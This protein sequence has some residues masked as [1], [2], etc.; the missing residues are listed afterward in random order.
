M[1]F[2]HIAD[3]HLGMQPDRG[4]AWS[5]ERGKDIWRSFEGVIDF[6]KKEKIDLLLIAGDLFHHQPLVRELKELNYLFTTIPQCK[7]VIMAGNHDYLRKD[8]NYLSFKFSKN[9]NMFMSRTMSSFYF[10]DIG[11]EVFGLSYDSREI[12]YPLY[13]NI[14]PSH[15]DRF[16][17]LLAHGGDDKHIPM[18]KEEMSKSGFHY[19]ALGHIHKPEILIPDT[20]AYAG[21][22]EPTDCNDMGS[23][24]FILGE[25]RG[26]KVRIQQVFCNLR[27]YVELQ[28]QVNGDTTN[29]ELRELVSNLI[30]EDGGNN[31]YKVQIIGY[32]DPEVE[33][34]LDSIYPLGDII[35]VEDQSEPDYDF[36]RLSKLH[37]DNLIGRYIHHFTQQGL[38]ESKKNALY[39]GVQALLD[40]KR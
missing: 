23:R 2:V 37:G 33:F 21:S 12:S 39:Y 35:S 20:M 18:K 24:G 16:N 30:E 36:Q 32:K 31:I 29:M 25:C 22:L 8:S 26:S 28:I 34:D 19:I 40:S 15:S 5:E 7:V 11:T 3:V 6:I 14:H 27:T 17:I 13:Q 38:D 1:R 4:R 10:E 9:V